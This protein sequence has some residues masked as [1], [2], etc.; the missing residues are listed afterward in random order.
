MLWSLP[1]RAQAAI[2]EVE[3]WTLTAPR[4]AWASVSVIQSD[5]DGMSVAGRSRHGA[6]VLARRR[7][8]GRPAVA[9]GAARSA[10]AGCATAVLRAAGGV[11]AIRR[12]RALG[13][14]RPT[15]LLGPAAALEVDDR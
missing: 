4:M 15:L 12:G 11:A 1:A 9:S 2:V 5:A 13:R 3:K 8:T 7:V 6:G 14:S 10:R